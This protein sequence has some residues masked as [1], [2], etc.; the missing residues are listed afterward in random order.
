MLFKTKIILALLVSFSAVSSAFAAEVNVYS[1]RKEHLIRPLLDAFTEETGVETKLVTDK[2]GKLIARLSQEGEYTQADVLITVDAGN[3]GNAKAKDLLQSIDSK[4]L[5]S[6]IPTHLRDKDNQW[7]GLSKRA[8]AIFYRKD[9]V[10]KDDV[11]DYEDLSSSK[12]YKQV[13]IRSSSNIYN[14]SLVASLIA[15][16]GE[17]S[18][19]SWARSV[20]DNM[21]RTPKGGDT[22][23]LRALA[24]G[25]GEIAVAN[26]YYYGR[27][28]GSDDPKKNAVAEKIG[29][30]FP[31]Q[32]GRGTHINVS[33]AGVTKHAKNKVEAV[34]LIEFLASKKAQKLLAKVNYEFPVNKKVKPHPVV[35]KWGKFKED[36]LSLTRLGELN[37]DAVLLMDRAGWK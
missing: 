6:I 10:K 3:L 31:N 29:I 8:R 2:A 22:D 27:L 16:D 34:Q 5:Q 18:A 23:Q 35:A 12:W 7:F 21:A 15:N 20:V 30:V 1:S 14:Q 4:K 13:L 36:E 28:I 24:A 17:G 19:S 37:T 11:R 33:G 32:N 25:E 9:A 26:T